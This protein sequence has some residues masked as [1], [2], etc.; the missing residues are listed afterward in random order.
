MGTGGGKWAFIVEDCLL[1]GVENHDPIC[2]KA[3]CVV[4]VSVLILGEPLIVCPF[5]LLNAAGYS[6]F[7]GLK[8][9]RKNPRPLKVYN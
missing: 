7:G 8:L 1:I 2:S 9:A 4:V 6:H 5:A 3:N